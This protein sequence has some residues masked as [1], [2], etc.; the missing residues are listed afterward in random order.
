LIR[1]VPTSISPRTALHEGDSV[2]LLEQVTLHYP[3]PLLRH[4]REI[5]P[6]QRFFE[7]HFRSAL[8]PPLSPNE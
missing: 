5:T 2:Q 1:L 7:R 3:E 6:G 4:D 8:G